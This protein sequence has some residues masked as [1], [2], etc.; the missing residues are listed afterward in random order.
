MSMTI[1]YELQLLFASLAVGLC[2]MAVYDGLRVFRVLVPHGNF[3]TGIEDTVY[4]AGSSITTFLLLFWQN[5]GVLRWYAILGVL[6]GMLVYNLTVSRILMKLLKK[7][8]K[9]L[10]IRKTKR[11]RL[12]RERLE[13]KE[14]KRS[15]KA[16]ESN[17]AGKQK[18][19]KKEKR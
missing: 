9:Y 7:V 10:T 3:W 13:V 19:K 12:R 1:R 15:R 5:D 4:W 8:E 16:E 14:K 6:A 17:N 11:Q 18:S 2:L